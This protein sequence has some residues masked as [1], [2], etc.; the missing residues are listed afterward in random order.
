MAVSK[1]C[2]TKYSVLLQLAGDEICHAI[3]KDEFLKKL[4]KNQLS[5]GFSV[6]V[7]QNIVVIKNL[8]RYGARPI[9]SFTS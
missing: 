5:E 8:S 9:F 3:S 6:K 1:M 7:P 4:S 2:E